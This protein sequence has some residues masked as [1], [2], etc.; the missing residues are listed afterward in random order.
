MGPELADLETSGT[1]GD[2]S[3]SEG[4]GRAASEIWRLR[5]VYVGGQG[6]SDGAAQTWQPSRA[7]GLGR[8][9]GEP[10]ESWLSIEDERV[11]REHARLYRQGAEVL[12]ED[13]GSRNGS[14][15]NGARLSKG[16]AQAVV[17]GDVLRLGDSFLIVRREPVVIA[18]AELPTLIGVSQAAC[19]LRAAIA[20]VAGRERSVLI[21]GESGTGKDV[22]AQAIHGA[23]GRTGP[24]VAVN[25]AAIPASL[26]E[27]TLFGVARGAFTGAVPHVG[28]FGEAEGGTLFL[29]EV[30][31]LPRELQPK[32]LRVLETGEVF[33]VG[34][35]R[36]IR[37]SVRIV[38]ATNRDLSAAL[39]EGQFREDLY[40][41]LAAETISLPPL[42]ERRE[43]ILLLAAK[44]GGGALALSPKLVAALLRYDFPR[45][46]RELGHLVRRLAD[47]GADAVDVQDEVLQ[48]LT[49]ALA[50]AV[51]V[52]LSPAPPVLATPR[53]AA[54]RPRSWQHGDPIPEKD[55]LIALLVAHRGNLSHIE[56][57]AGYSRRQFRRWLD[58][59]GIDPTTFRGRSERA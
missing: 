41:R 24:L 15:L 7:L 36:P 2:G 39:H 53:S 16:Q 21:T 8:R 30:G 3:R 22:T 1:T 50:R 34:S 20:R 58:Q 43:D 54:P 52:A 42:R 38:A 46:I 18:D 55:Q 17:D 25:C 51:T 27:A 47:A 29:D 32:L 35:Q 49:P 5:V 4:R 37:R 11:S 6:I 13:L 28:L 56:A 31:D 9:R 57:A 14:F 48:A 40:A 26:A 19:R 59:Y 45:N 12:V 23:S 33:A 10:D 44:Y